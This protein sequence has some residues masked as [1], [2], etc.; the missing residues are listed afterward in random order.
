[1]L[2]ALFSDEDERTAEALSITREILLDILEN[3]D[4]ESYCTECDER[5]ECKY[6]NLRGIFGSLALE[7]DYDVISDDPILRKLKA[8]GASNLFGSF[9]EYSALLLIKRELRRID[10]FR[11]GQII[12]IVVPEIENQERII[13]SKIDSKK[14]EMQAELKIELEM[15]LN[16]VVFANEPTLLTQEQ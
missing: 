2:I 13:D 10:E 3:E 12:Q 1:M 16:N 8:L 11:L 4:L 6:S 15:Y 7:Y 9:V 14:E 5:E